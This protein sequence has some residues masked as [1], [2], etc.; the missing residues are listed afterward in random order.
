MC[1]DLSVRS[2]REKLFRLWLQSKA[3]RRTGFAADDMRSPVLEDCRTAG[4]FLQITMNELTRRAGVQRWALHDCDNVMYMSA[5]KREIP[6]ALFVHVVRDGRDAALS[7]RKQHPV[8]PMLWPRKRALLAWALLWQWTV[9]KGRRFAQ[10]FPSDYMEV[11]FEELVQHPAK[12]LASLGAFLDHDLD[13]SR[14]QQNAIGRLLSPNTVWEDEKQ[15]KSFSPINR[16]KTKLSPS[17][18]A[19]IETVI[20][21]GLEEFDYPLSHP[22]TGCATTAPIAAFMRL[23]YPAFFQTK[24]FLR[25]RTL[26]GRLTKGARLELAKD[27]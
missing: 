20:G 8:N 16:W 17:E 11:R 18:I 6:N 4:D 19:G 3:F 9:R 14:I 2:H 13:Y 25:D 27:N 7:M 22:R 5:I 15:A 1:G 26:V 24:L 23:F 12:T 21:D 10:N